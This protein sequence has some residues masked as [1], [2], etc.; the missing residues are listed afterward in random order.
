MNAKKTMGTWGCMHTHTKHMITCDC[1]NVYTNCMH[2][3]FNMSC[4]KI[5]EFIYSCATTTFIY[6]QCITCIGGAK[7]TQHKNNGVVSTHQTHKNG[8]GK[9]MDGGMNKQNKKLH[10]PQCHTCKN[11]RCQEVECCD[12]RNWK[13]AERRA[14]ILAKMLEAQQ[15]E[16]DVVCID[17][18]D[19]PRGAWGQVFIQPKQQNMCCGGDDNIKSVVI[20]C[21]KKY[22]EYDDFYP[23]HIMVVCQQ[24][25]AI[26]CI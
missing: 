23:L 2:D 7:M 20:E 11:T 8:V 12:G 9:Q 3:V 14:K 17:T 5:N 13:C 18:T 1:C 26:V 15:N 19:G 6:S 10:I 16:Y 24:C 22:Q 25:Q 4:E 21:I